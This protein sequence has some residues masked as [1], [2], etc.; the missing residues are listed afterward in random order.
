MKPV[1][2]AAFNSRSEAEPLRQQLSAAG[3][4]AEIRPE[5][6][7]GSG[8]F[9]RPSAGVRLQVPREDFERALQLVYE[10]NAEEGTTSDERELQRRWMGGADGAVWSRGKAPG[11]GV[12]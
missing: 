9:E 7:P 12:V 4:W 2:L 5:S 10:W 1:T 11:G 8:P 6:G 3:I